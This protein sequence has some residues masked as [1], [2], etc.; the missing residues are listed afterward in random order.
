MQDGELVLGCSLR[1]VLGLQL[2]GW[3][4]REV[5]EEAISL[6]EEVRTQGESGESS[7]YCVQS[8]TRC[9]PV[10]GPSMARLTSPD[11]QV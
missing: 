5:C 7:G 2:C 8:C 3:N 6:G 4:G 10:W 1:K 9:G 11:V